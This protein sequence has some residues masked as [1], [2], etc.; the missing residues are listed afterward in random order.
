MR[1]M[2]LSASGE[3]GGAERS[4]L[5]ILASVR[6]AAPSWRLALA[7]GSDGPLVEHASRLGVASSVLPFPAALSR[8]GEAGIE[9]DG[10]RAVGFAAQMARAM[11]PVLRYRNQ[12]AEAIREFRPDVIHSNGLKTHV[13]SAWT[14]PRQAAVVWH[15][16][17][18]VGSRPV[19]ARLLRASL[20]SC[21]EVVCNSASVARDARAT[22][23]R[24]IQVTPVLNAVDLDRFNVEG[25]AV[26]L[27]TLA[28]LP[29]AGPE[30]VRVGLLGTFGRWKGHRIFLEA[31]AKVPAG[32]RVRGYIIGGALYQTAH[33]Q[34]S[35]DD[36][37]RHAAALQLNGRIGFTGF[38]ADADRAMRALD[39]VVHAS[40]AP[41]P[42]G[43]VI[44]EA[45]ACGRAVIAAD[46]GGAREIVEPGVD[47]LMHEPGN[48]QSLADRIVELVRCSET[49][50]NLGAAG[51]RTALR[52]FDRA[53]LASDLIPVYQR[54][55]AARTPG[56]QARG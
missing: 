42:F 50:R 13:L 14:R 30:V 41:E 12:L 1:V 9:P 34:H 33:S 29:A 8:L 22:L 19:T 15:L 27:D 2:Y 51:R 49:R 44:A 3:M 43:L 39:V 21:A 4:L 36:L 54:S 26:D 38:V 25:E 37:R 16:H 35:L 40:T 52:R 31:L 24:T 7:A 18:Y 46:A 6:T 23:G 20:R 48:A 32:L 55:I 5:D 17:D 47:A 10:A 11:M 56:R 45:M 28:G 53:R